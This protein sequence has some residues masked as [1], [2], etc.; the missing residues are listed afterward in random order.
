MADHVRQQLVSAAKTRVT[1]LATTGNKVFG[2][3]VNPLQAGELPGL[4]IYA[5]G[6]GATPSTIHSPILYERAVDVHVVGYAARNDDLDAT[7]DLISKE[8]ETA[9]ASALTV[10]GKTVEMVYRGCEKTLEAGEKQAGSVDMTF[11]ATIYNAANA[12][13]VLS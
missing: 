6:D 13:D 7:L 4:C 1:N 3:R 11:S 12:P 5:E 9:L 2:F 8:V 10:G